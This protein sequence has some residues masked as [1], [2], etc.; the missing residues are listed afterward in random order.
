MALAVGKLARESDVVLMDLRGLSAANAG[1]LFE[2]R[3]L[4]GRGLLPRVVF[5]ADD[6]TDVALL[7]HVRL[8]RV[9]RLDRSTLGSLLGERSLA[10]TA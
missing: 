8:F 1:C 9:R 7:E 10:A 5:V 6:R 3:E 4:A 2:L